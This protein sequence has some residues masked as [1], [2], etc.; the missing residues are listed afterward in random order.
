MTQL[1][2]FAGMLA[3]QSLAWPVSKKP[4]KDN[5][6]P[7]Y[8]D[9]DC[10]YRCC[11]YTQEF[12]ESG[13]CLEI[14]EVDRCEDRKRN[15]RIAIWVILIVLIISWVSLY[16]FKLKERQVSADRLAEIKTMKAREEELNPRNDLLK[17]ND[18]FGKPGLV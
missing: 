12:Y 7:C 14:S 17:R 4:R 2:A 3:M 10:T 11:D 15:H 9:T 18:R 16:V 1:L 8:T 5:T 13:Q 6:H